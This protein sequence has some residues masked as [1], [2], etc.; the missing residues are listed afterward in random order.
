M[1]DCWDLKAFLGPMATVLAAAAAV[2]VTWRIGR[3]Q[4]RI[5]QGQAE[6]AR[7][8]REIAES[9]RDIAFDKLK[10]DLFQK[11]YEIYTAAKGIMERVTRTGTQR[12]I[13]DYELLSMRVKLDEGRF[14]FPAKQMALYET[15]EQL[16]TQ[17][18]VAR[19]V[20][21]RYNDDDDIRLRQGDVMA[22]AI[23]RLSE[24]YRQFPALMQEEMEFSQLTASA[25]SP[26]GGLEPKA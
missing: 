17:H 8:Q 24:I 16:T 9:Q 14:F 22:D 19:L 11:R 21:M 23:D 18:E 3:E 10:Y 25:H 26:R 15:I 1:V 2:F 7:A 12:P 6:T 20:W 5:A 13:D 4:V